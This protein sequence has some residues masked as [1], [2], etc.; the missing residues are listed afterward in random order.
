MTY[1]RE[2]RGQNFFALDRNLQDLLE[3]I[4]AKAATKYRTTLEDFGA[5]VGGPV[6]EERGR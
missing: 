2:T 4:D 6:D 3:R 1:A 5:W